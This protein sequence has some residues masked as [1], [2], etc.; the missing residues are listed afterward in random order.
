MDEYLDDILPKGE[1]VE[2]KCKSDR[3]TLL[4][5][6]RRVTYFRGRDGPYLPV[7]RV[8]HAYPCAL[9]RVTVDK[10]AI[11]YIFSGADIMCP[12]LTSRGGRLD[13]AL[14]AGA[15]VAV[16]AEGKQHALAVGVLALSTEDMCVCDCV[17]PRWR[18]RVG[19]VGGREAHAAPIR[20]RV[21]SVR[22]VAR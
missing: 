2:A 7:L 9:P 17:A 22:A 15:A 19:G 18:A 10:G 8:L 12:G 13:V 1:V 14:P 16:H 4:V 20:A 21:P 11:K 3:T 6:N 5:V